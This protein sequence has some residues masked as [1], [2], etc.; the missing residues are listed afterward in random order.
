MNSSNSCTVC[1]DLSPWAP[2]T[3]GLFGATYK[4]GKQ[5]F[6]IRIQAKSIVDAADSGCA[7][8]LMLQHGLEQM[9]SIK[10]RGVSSM[11]KIVVAGH[12]RQRS[13]V[14]GLQ[15]KDRV[16]FFSTSRSCCQRLVGRR[17]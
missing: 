2:E 6:V 1:G 16:E 3:A 4:S 17:Y 14:A 5:Q 8:C 9:T 10:I 7:E 15:G 13:V 11:V 12:P